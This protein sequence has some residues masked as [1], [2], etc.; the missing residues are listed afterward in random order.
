METTITIYPKSQRKFRYQS[1]L[2]FSAEAK[3][4]TLNTPFVAEGPK[5]RLGFR[6][7]GLG[8]LVVSRNSGVHAYLIPI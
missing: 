2:G 3:L 1:I 6:V 5:Y 8:L 4:R 7:Y